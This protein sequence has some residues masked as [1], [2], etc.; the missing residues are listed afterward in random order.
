MRVLKVRQQLEHTENED[1]C[2]L[3]DS[4]PNSHWPEWMNGWSFTL[5][6]LRLKLEF[7]VKLFKARVCL[8]VTVRLTWLVFVSESLLLFHILV[9]SVV[10]H[11]HTHTR[12][13]KKI[14]KKKKNTAVKS[15]V[16]QGAWGS[17]SFYYHF[18][19]HCRLLHRRSYFWSDTK[20]ELV[21][22]LMI[23]K[24]EEEFRNSV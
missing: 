19:R 7:R 14:K 1:V 3:T 11:T 5:N 20:E 9:N 6:L 16:L 13:N 21:T 8:H 15:L 4:F 10:L 22:L 2:V 12:N 23:T 18:T 24:E 17:F